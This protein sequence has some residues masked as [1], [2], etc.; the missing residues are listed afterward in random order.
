MCASYFTSYKLACTVCVLLSENI[1]HFSYVV[2]WL[3]C[4]YHVLS[5]VCMV[6]TCGKNTAVCSCLISHTFHFIFLWCYSI[7]ESAMYLLP[8]YVFMVLSTE[9]LCVAHDAKFFRVR[10]ISPLV[11]F[12]RV[13]CACLQCAFTWMF[14]L[15]YPLLSL[16]W[17][18][19]FTCIA[20]AIWCL[21]FSPRRF[22]Q[23]GTS[24][25]VWV[26][27]SRPPPPPVLR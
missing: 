14:L 23:F 13:K 11:G 5:C 9:F 26:L 21:I 1:R 20:S 24:G 3:R 25:L 4:D 16:A 27:F 7:F 18:S 10:V 22:H 8:Y 6:F 17:C 2:W 19:T 15:F 12:Q